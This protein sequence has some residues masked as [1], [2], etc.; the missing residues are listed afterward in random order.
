MEKF[1]PRA[2]RKFSKEVAWVNPTNKGGGEGKLKPKAII[3]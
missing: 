1:L 2:Y 3:N